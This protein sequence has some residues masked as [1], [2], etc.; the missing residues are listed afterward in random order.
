[1]STYSTNEDTFEIYRDMMDVT[2]MSRPNVG[3]ILVDKAGHA[4]RWLEDGKLATHYNPSAHYEIPSLVWVKDGEKYW[5]DDDQPHDV[6]HHECRICG[7]H[8]VPP[9]CADTYQQ[10][11][12]GL[13]HYKI[14]GLSVSKEEFERRRPR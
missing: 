12:P 9:Y 1:M 6:G 14:N 4:H 11:A 13:V 10:Y 7:E 8:I 2:S 3:C 5:E